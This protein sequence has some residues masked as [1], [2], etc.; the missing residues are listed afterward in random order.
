M[1]SETRAWLA[2]A[3]ENL[4]AAGLSLR[5]GHLNVCLQNAQQA[6]EKYLK[7]V[8][9]EKGFEFRRTHNIRELAG[10]LRGNGVDPGMS[11]DDMDLLD[12][13]Y[14]PSK[15]PVFSSLPHA[16]PDA[17]VCE[18]AIEAA[19]HLRDAVPGL[20]RSAEGY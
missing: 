19:S 15:Y 20:L 9:I 10:V 11:E 3:D 2:Y 12:A 17:G 13:I 5:H 6:A 8:M 14:V 16:E 1:K 4:A 7:A 18:R